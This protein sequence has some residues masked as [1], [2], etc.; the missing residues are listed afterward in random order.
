MPRTIPA[1]MRLPTLED[2][3]L[4]TLRTTIVTGGIYPH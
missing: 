1:A 2:V 3:P 4:I